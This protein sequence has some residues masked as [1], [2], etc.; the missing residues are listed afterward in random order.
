[1]RLQLS[2]A[3]LVQDESPMSRPQPFRFQPFAHLRAGAAIL[4]QLK[5]ITYIAVDVDGHAYS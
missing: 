4:L 2:L 5:P 3:D 1:M